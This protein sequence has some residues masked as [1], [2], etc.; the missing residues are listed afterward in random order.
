MTVTLRLFF[1]GGLKAFALVF[2]DFRFVFSLGPLRFNAALAIDFKQIALTLDAK[3][4]L[5][6]NWSWFVI[7]R[8]TLLLSCGVVYRYYFVF[9]PSQTIATC[10]AIDLQQGLFSNTETR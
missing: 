8:F 2:C 1:F 6:H 7:L 10:I 5:F 3:F 4:K 9:D